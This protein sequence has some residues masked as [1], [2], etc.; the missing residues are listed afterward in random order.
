MDITVYLP[1]ALGKRAKEADLKFSRLLRDAVEKELANME[2]LANME[3]R[4]IKLEAHD[5][6]AQGETIFV[7]FEGELIFSLGDEVS[8]YRKKSG[9]IVMHT[10]GRY[11]VLDEADKEEIEDYLTRQGLPDDLRVEA[12]RRLGVT[13]TIDI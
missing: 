3:S 11:E 6:D 5:P 7:R 10:F 12:S 9:G 13:P 1:D 8:A 4:E 2:T